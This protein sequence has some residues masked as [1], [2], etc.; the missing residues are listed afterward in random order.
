MMN[1]IQLM[2]YL[3][4]DLEIDVH[5]QGGEM[6]TLSLSTT[7]SWQLC[8][9]E[10]GQPISWQKQAELFL[11]TVFKP[12]LIVWLKEEIK[13]GN[14]QKGDLIFLQGSLSFVGGSGK[15]RKT[16]Q[17]VVAG[18]WGLLFQLHINN[19]YQALLLAKAGI[20]FPTPITLETSN[21]N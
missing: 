13:K 8:S 10:G 1:K 12:S 3:D 9:A 15:R 7:A 14:F 6:A 21:D 18:P 19:D 16:P 11:I 5:R 2:G 4:Q 20:K 17:I